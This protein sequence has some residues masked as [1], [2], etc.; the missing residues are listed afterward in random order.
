M[1]YMPFFDT[2]KNFSDEIPAISRNITSLSVGNRPDAVSLYE[3]A[4]DY[5]YLSLN[6]ENSYKSY[7]T[8]LTTF[9]NW[10][11][12]K[13]PDK[14]LRFEN[15]KRKELT[16]YIEWCKNPGKELIA[17][18]SKVQFITDKGTGLKVPNP[19]WRPFVTRSSNNL[20][21]PTAIRTKLSILS[22]FYGYL[23][24]QEYVEHN[25]AS[26]LLKR[27]YKNTKDYIQGEDDENIKSMS[28]LQWMYVMDTANQ[29]A[30]EDPDKHERTLFMLSLMYSCYP[31]ISEISSRTGYMPMMSL[32]RR[33]KKTNLWGFHIPQSKRNKS[34]TVSVS[35][36][37]LGSLSRYRKHL[38][39][40]LVFKALPELPTPNDTTPLV[41]TL[42][43]NSKGEFQGN[44]ECSLGIRRI[45]EIIEE[46]FALASE[47]L[48]ADGLT[49]DADE[50]SN[51]TPHSI[52]HTG[53]S[54][55][56]NLNRRPLSHVQADAGHDDISTTSLYL[57][58]RR[59]ERYESAKNKKINL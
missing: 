41:P 21:S 4:H 54:H 10:F 35:D 31:R 32:F 24:E 6:N 18:S 46:V 22:M 51:M 12:Y 28:E 43:T 15:I 5:L 25:P 44:A 38:R 2:L 20:L 17:S 8:E 33:D 36:E 34:R 37:L 49:Y 42:R 11:F 57:H 29:L 1:N 45:R 26:I 7:R 14:E 16:E 53:I 23:N 27:Q 52:R 58:T 56:I 48:R 9:L 30:I 50:L 40:S 39:E 19:A 59:E 3:H 55:D 13:E 47:R